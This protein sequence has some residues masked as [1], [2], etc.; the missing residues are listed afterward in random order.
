MDAHHEV[1]VKIT[2]ATLMALK[3]A[4]EVT[5]LAGNEGG[6]IYDAMRKIT[7]AALANEPECVLK[8]K[9]EG[10]EL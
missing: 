7:K 8:R 1:N 2:N 4:L 9:V 6:I 5:A 10:S 3:R